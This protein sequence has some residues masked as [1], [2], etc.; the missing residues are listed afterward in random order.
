MHVSRGNQI[1]TDLSSV[2]AVNAFCKVP[3]AKFVGTVKDSWK[4]V[5]EVKKLTSKFMFEVVRGWKA[6]GM[7]CAKTQR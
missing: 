5:K 2:C 1:N 6:Q 4:E 7:G 3:L